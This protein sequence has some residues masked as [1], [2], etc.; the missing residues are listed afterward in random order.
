MLGARPERP[1][2]PGPARSDK[3]KSSEAV[4]FK[5]TCLVRAGRKSF[6]SVKLKASKISA[7][8]GQGEKSR[9]GEAAGFKFCACP[10]RAECLYARPPAGKENKEK[11][12]EQL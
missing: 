6:S 3:I 5:N 9:L 1:L 12:M 8:P 10:G 11:R 2:S 4:S 7:P